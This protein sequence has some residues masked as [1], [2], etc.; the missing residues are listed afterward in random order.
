MHF[1]IDRGHGAFGNCIGA[2]PQE[3]RQK[4]VSL[5][6]KLFSVLTM[7]CFCL[8]GAPAQASLSLYFS[9]DYYLGKAFEWALAVDGGFNKGDFKQV[10]DKTSQLRLEKA[11]Q[12]IHQYP[13]WNYRYSSIKLVLIQGKADEPNAFSIGPVIYFSKSLLALLDD[14]DL[15]AVLAHE[16]AHSEKA[17]LL[18]RVPVPLGAVF[19]SVFEHVK[20]GTASR[21][22]IQFLVEAVRSWVEK[23]NFSMELQAD[24]FAAQQLQYMSS[25][26]LA[27]NPLD[28]LRATSKMLGYDVSLDHSDNP[29]ANRA[30]AIL[31]KSYLNTCE[32]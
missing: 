21:L 24:C 28:L 6:K 32:F 31:A 26:G 10:E 15:T 18:K 17:H 16:M 27:N 7:T 20:A 22:Q 5:I 14:R 12:Q 23:S 4:G 19:L 9:P 1:F 30:Q 8:L 13:A 11:F 3:S 25:K 29:D 2:R